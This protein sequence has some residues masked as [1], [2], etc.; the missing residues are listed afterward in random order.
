MPAL[1]SPTVKEQA[2][3]R[4]IIALVALALSSPASAD[5]PYLAVEAGTARAKSNDVDVTVDYS[6]SAGAIFDPPK[7]DDVFATRYKRGPDLGLLAGYD[8]GW[9]RVEAELAQKR[10]RI[11]S[12]GPDDITDEFLGQVNDVLNRPSEAPDPGAP[13]LPALALADFQPLG[14]V[15]VG[16]A[17]VSVALDLRVIDG[18]NAYAGMGF[19]RSFARGYG[20][21]DSSLAKQRFV[22][23]RYALSERFE[24]G[25]KYRKFASGVIK[26]DNDAASYPGNPDLV[27]QGG[28]STVRTVNAAAAS[29]IEGEFR[30]KSYLLS[31]VYNL[32]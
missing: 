10:T 2:L 12:L 13:G 15:K 23:A 31:L 25:L 3:N 11:L 24:V 14:T 5:Y 17:M 20:D 27:T 18:L 29:N 9:F 21:R 19:G 16:S 8:F 6:P 22:G 7:Y 4:S 28:T 30:T 26:L 1:R 32:R